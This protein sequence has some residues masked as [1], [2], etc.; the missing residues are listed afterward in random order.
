MLYVLLVLLLLIVIYC[1]YKIRILSY[2]IKIFYITVLALTYG[3][4]QGNTEKGFSA[5]PMLLNFH[6][7]SASSNIQSVLATWNASQTFI[8]YHP[9]LFQDFEKVSDIEKDIFK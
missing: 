5:I 2:R 6:G 1:I 8:A 4:Q 3:V 7:L 9:T